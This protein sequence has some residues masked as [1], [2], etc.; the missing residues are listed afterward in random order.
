[1]LVAQNRNAEMDGVGEGQENPNPL[2][3]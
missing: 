1:M 3:D 2:F